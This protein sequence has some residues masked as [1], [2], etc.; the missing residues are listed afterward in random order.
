MKKA[1]PFLRSLAVAAVIPATVLLLASCTA[2][3]GGSR[4]FRSDV[5]RRVQGGL[6]AAPPAQEAVAPAAAQPRAAVMTGGRCANYSPAAGADKNVTMLA[7]P[8]GDPNSSAVMVH[9]ILPKQVRANQTF[10]YEI[11]VTNLSNAPL[12]NVVVFDQSAENLTISESDPKANRGTNGRSEWMIGDLGPCATRVIKVTG[13]SGGAG[14][15]S[16][17]LTVSYANYLCAVTQVVDLKL[18]ITKSAPAEVLLC[19]NIPITIVVKNSGTGSIENVMVVDPLPAGLS[20]LDNKTNVEFAVGTLA[21]GE[22]KT[23]NLTAKAAKTGRYE[24]GA[25]AAAGDIKAI[26]NKTTTVVKQPVL[27]LTCECEG[28]EYVGRELTCKYTVKNTGDAA[29]ANTVLTVPVPGNTS[30]VNA[31]NGGTMSGNAVSWNLGSIAPGASQTVSVNLKTTAIGMV[32]TSATAVCACASP[33]TSN[34]SSE[35]KGIP[36]ILL[37][38]VDID[39]PIEVGDNE[40][41][42]VTVTNQGSADDTNVRVVVVLPAQFEFVSASGAT[43]GKAVGQTVTFDA[44]AALAPK[45]VAEFRIVAK[46]KSAGDARL[47]VQMTSDQFKNPPI[48]ETESTNVYD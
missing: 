47:S 26:S 12:E 18:E 33:V 35:V 43:A 14:S 17:C 7:F 30:F 46:A 24:N 20:T 8:S 13:R 28:S 39:D 23:L 11:H 10:P 48:S 38:V 27:T 2:Q 41:F 37:E 4:G 34:C 32:N 44:I 22:S 1:T 19:D 40:T 21:A 3:H 29:C 9:Q 42:V 5:D 45:A 15:A 36:A 6:R 16:N 25:S 31:A